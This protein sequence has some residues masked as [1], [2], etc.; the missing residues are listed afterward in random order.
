MAVSVK[1]LRPNTNGARFTVVAKE[2]DLYKG[3]P[4]PGLVKAKRKKTSARNSSGRMTVERRGGGHKRLLRKIDFKRNKDGIPARVE[5]LEYDPNR[6]AHIALLV[7]KDGERRYIIAPRGVKAGAKLM[8]GPE[9]AI[10]VGNT[11]PLRKIPEGTLIHCVEMKPGKGAQ[12]IRSAGTSAVLMAKDDDG[13]Y[14]QI[15]LKSGERRRVLA[16][17]RATIGEVGFS[18]HGLKVLGKAGASRRLGR[19]PRVRGVAKNPVDHAMGG[20]EGK[21][22]GGRHPV[23]KKGLPTKGYKTRRKKKDSSKYIVR[24]R[25]QK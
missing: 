17:C 3:R 19:R 11:L 10:E 13:R 8:S 21:T 12:M 6:T 18:E 4:Y 2:E 7:Y 16:D 23:T 1:K 25:R 15:K 20:G 24:D 5:R 9:A 22:S 14:V